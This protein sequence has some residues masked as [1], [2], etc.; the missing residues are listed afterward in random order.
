MG[1][2]L[3]QSCP[4]DRGWFASWCTS[5]CPH[6]LELRSLRT[7]PIAEPP[8]PLK[9]DVLSESGHIYK[10]DYRLGERM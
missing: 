2:A 5:L 3:V 1:V 7:S 8:L 10:L 9:L 6:L 4:S